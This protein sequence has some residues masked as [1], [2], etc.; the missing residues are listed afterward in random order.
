M[1]MLAVATVAV[2]TRVST[3]PAHRSVTA[4]HL[5]TPGSDPLGLLP[6]SEGA[7]QAA[8]LHSSSGTSSDQSALVI[9]RDVSPPHQYPSSAQGTVR[10]RVPRRRTNCASASPPTWTKSGCSSS[11]SG[12]EP[13]T[14]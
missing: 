8:R 14:P 5:P 4:S 3:Y 7:A 11:S 6:D 10:R 13:P 9:G 1:S 12:D 2:S